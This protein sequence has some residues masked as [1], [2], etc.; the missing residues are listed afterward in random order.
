MIVEALKTIENNKEKNPEQENLSGIQNEVV[1]NELTKLDTKVETKKTATGEILLLMKD[2]PMY[3]KM[4]DVLKT[5]EKVK[6]FAEKIENTV[7]KYIDQELTTFP[8]VMKK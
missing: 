4:K 5:D 7:G 6:E 8:D 3:T 1:E 2:T